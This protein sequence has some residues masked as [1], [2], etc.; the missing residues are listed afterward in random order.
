MR[1]AKRLRFVLLLLA[2]AGGAVADDGDWKSVK[3]DDGVAAWT[4][5]SGDGLPIARAT[6][7]VAA[8]LC[9]VLAIVRDVSRHCE[10]MAD[11]VEARTV[12]RGDWAELDMLLRI[13]GYPLVG[14]A[15][16]DA[17]LRTRTTF[18]TAGAAAEVS[19]SNLPEPHAA[20][21]AG[22]V[23]MPRL[24]GTYKLKRT[25]PD[26]TQVEYRFE[27]DLGGWVP[28]WVATRTVE[29]L[30]WRTL[31]N[32]RSQAAKAA[33]SYG[34]EIGSWPAVDGASPCAPPSGG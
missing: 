32:L 22:C 4:R 5:D 17:V 15:D 13:K 24:A 20:L 23:H 12:R 28:G 21:A 19:F 2:A 31:V 14:V 25:A 18:E 8:P 26:V 16:R 9:V 10:W 27:V 29:Q 34:D 30:P 11:C 7:T 6:T 3:D 33:S 1:T